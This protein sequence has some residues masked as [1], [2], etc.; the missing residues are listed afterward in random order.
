MPLIPWGGMRNSTTLLT[1]SE[2]ARR[3]SLAPRTIKRA[4]KAGRIPVVDVGF[5]VGSARLRVSEAD[6][7]AW[8]EERK[9]RAAS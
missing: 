7:T 4:I 8:I 1:V 9:G 3:L 5:G 6:L 2:V